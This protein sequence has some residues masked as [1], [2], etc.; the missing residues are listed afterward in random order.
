MNR[1]ETLLSAP[2]RS[3]QDRAQDIPRRAADHIKTGA[4][5][6][7]HSIL[8]LEPGSVSKFYHYDF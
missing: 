2:D 6:S 3:P 8:E 1:E 4:L 7:D 5:S